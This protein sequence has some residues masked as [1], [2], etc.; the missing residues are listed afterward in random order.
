MNKNWN[1]ISCSK[2][3]MLKSLINATLLNNKQYFNGFH[4]NIQ[5]RFPRLDELK[6]FAEA[7]GL[8]YIC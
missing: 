4:S 8:D 1:S 3:K 6:L 5:S 7:T 2:F